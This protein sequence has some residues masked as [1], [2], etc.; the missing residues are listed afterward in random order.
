MAKTTVMAKILEFP[1]HYFRKMHVKPTYVV[2]T[3]T[4]ARLGRWRKWK[5]HRACVAQAAEPAL[6]MR[7]MGFK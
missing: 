2:L 4:W 3:I 6:V 5:V 1:K 7:K